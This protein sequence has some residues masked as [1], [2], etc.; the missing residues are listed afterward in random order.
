[1]FLTFG[2]KKGDGFIKMQEVFVVFAKTRKIN[3]P[4]FV[5]NYELDI[6][7]IVRLFEIIR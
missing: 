2:R 5:H 4:A 7:L 3:S 1:M 6:T